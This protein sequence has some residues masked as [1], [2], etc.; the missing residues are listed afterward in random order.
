M[1]LNRTL[2]WHRASAILF[3]LTLLLTACASS[4]N[5]A[6]Q[7]QP[8]APPQAAATSTPSSS[9][10]LAVGH[11]STAPA[12][13]AASAPSAS[14]TMM[15]ESQGGVSWTAPSRW[16]NNPGAGSSMRAAT[17]II[18]AAAGDSEGAECAVFK[19]I[20]GGVAANIKRWI[21]QFEQ[22]DGSSSDS[23]AKQNK[24]TING[25]SVTTVDLTGTFK[26]GG[27]MMTGQATAKKPGYRL[28]GAIVEAPQGEIFFKLT[29]PEKTVAA[30]E[31]EFQSLLKSIKK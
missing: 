7:N 20:G 1:S 16:K 25:L 13:T 14:S 31:S 24:E 15:T 5:E 6:A 26:G 18:P 4:S 28:L 27:M 19:N 30:A 22:P 23:K 8:S 11:D 12:T 10:V 3:S 2:I 21:D 17:Y 9:S 29:G